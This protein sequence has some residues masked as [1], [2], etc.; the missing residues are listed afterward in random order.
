MANDHPG[1]FDHATAF[2]D[3]FADSRG[4]IGGFTD[5]QQHRDGTYAIPDAMQKYQFML[6]K[7]DGSWIGLV[8]P[9]DPKFFFT[10]TPTQ[11]LFIHN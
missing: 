4:S 5:I 1:P 10:N 9:F 8:Q 3:L 2:R 6:T 7:L 11:H